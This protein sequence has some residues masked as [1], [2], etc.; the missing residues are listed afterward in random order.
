[1]KMRRF[2]L[3]LDAAL[4]KGVAFRRET[5]GFFHCGEVVDEAALAASVEKCYDGAIELDVGLGGGGHGVLS[6]HR[7]LNF[8]EGG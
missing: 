1:M 4:L 7:S 8:R 2:H 3:D 5:K 6:L